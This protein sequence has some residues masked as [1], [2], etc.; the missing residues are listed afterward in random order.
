[1]KAI[2][3]I[4]ALGVGLTMVGATIFGASAAYTLSQWPSP[5][6]ADGTPASNLAIVVGDNA[7][8]SDV[9]GAIDVGVALQAA[10][11]TKTAVPGAKRGVTVE[12]DAVAIGSTS[13]LLEIN[14]TIGSVRETLTEVDLDML[15][16]GQIVTDEGSTEYNQYLRFT[17]TDAF[18][19][20]KVVFDEDE[21]DRVGHYLFWDDNTQVFE[22]ELE[23]EEG[24]E[25]EID[26]DDLDDLEDEDVLILGQPFV[27]VDSD[28]TGGLVTGAGGVT[29]FTIELMGGAIS[30]LLG[31]NDKETYV[32][33]GKEY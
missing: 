11:V 23:F 19:S 10:A 8:A 17:S 28:L 5:F 27:I 9:A 30:A 14:E 21:R 16:G 22:W 25:S 3:K 26:G 33:D 18:G 29:R 24:L 20:G 15:K 31:E 6:I 1:M 7:A 13:D 12:G 2:K 32:V 4:V